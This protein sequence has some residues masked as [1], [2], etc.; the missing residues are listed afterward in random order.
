MVSTKRGR[1]RSAFWRSIG[2]FLLSVPLG[3][4]AVEISNGIPE[5]TVGHFR[6]DVE[7]AG[8]TRRVLVTAARFPSN[9]IVTRNVV[10]NYYSFV[11]AANNG[12]GVRLRAPLPVPDAINPN[13][14]TTN[15]S[16][17]GINGLISWTAVSSIAPGAQVMT[18]TYTFIAEPGKVL[19]FLRFLQ[20]LDGVVLD[21]SDDVF[22]HR[23]SAVGGDLKLF[24]FDNTD[25]YG[26][27]HSGALL[28][29]NDLQN[30]SFAGWAADHFDNIISSISTAGQPV[31]PDA[32]P[33]NLS[34]FQHP[35]LGPVFG[36]A[37]NVSVLA[38]DV[39][40]NATSAVITT[41]LGAVPISVEAQPAG[42]LLAG[43][44]LRCRRKTN[45]CTF[46][47]TCIVSPSPGAPCTNQVNVT[48]TKKALGSRGGPPSVEFAFGTVNVAPGPNVTVQLQLTKR[49]RN[50]VR[51]TPKKKINGR[52]EIKSSDGVPVA[53]RTK[54]RITN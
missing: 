53:F 13:H 44:Q 11:D 47:V 15:G 4:N 41:S 30:A 20:H 25:V 7:D 50:F 10:R 46:R 8:A 12:G 9:D 16:F 42:N 45:K 48:V 35:Q 23:G 3:T 52:L 2:V 49:G 29:G 40:P 38:W 19:G 37:D 21:G 43:N 32:I 39:A 33:A 22:F 54:I 17:L 24:S 18:T 51:S 6:V 31:S 28:P 26:L 5:G 1:F 36:P 27:S 34:S 14:V